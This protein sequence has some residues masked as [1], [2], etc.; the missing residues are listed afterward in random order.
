MLTILIINFQVWEEKYIPAEEAEGFVED[1]KTTG[2]EYKQVFFYT[3]G[4]K[5]FIHGGYKFI[6]RMAR[7]L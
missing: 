5:K 2:E 1:C 4:G 3:C 6:L 7:L